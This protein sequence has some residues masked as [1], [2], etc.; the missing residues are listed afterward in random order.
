VF[1]TNSSL[2]RRVLWQSRRCWP[3]LFAIFLLSVLAMGLSLIVPLPLKIAVDS[4][5]GTSAL[6]AFLQPYFPQLTQK[7]GL[8]LA[9]CLMLSTALLINLQG[10]CSGWLQTYTG[11]KLVWDFRAQLLDHVQRL[12]M[13]FHDRNGTLDSAY[14]IQHDA[15]AIQYVVIQGLVPMCTA[16]SALGIMLYVCMRLD[17]QISLIAL[18]IAVPL[19]LLT[20]ACSRQVRNRSNVVKELDSSA[21]N[22]VQEVL[23]SIRLVKAF[24]QE[25][26]EYERFVRHSEKRQARQVKLAFTQGLFNLTIG[27]VIA[28]GSAAA[29]YVGVRHVSMGK[30]TVGDLLI[31]V[32]YIAQLYEP[33]RLV[34][35]KITDLHGWAASLE[36]ALMLLDET[37]EIS[38][39]SNPLPLVRARGH[40]EFR[41]VSFQYHQ[42]QRGLRSI[43]FQVPP[44]ARVGVMGSS[45][46]GKSTLI[47]LLMRFYDP[48]EGA[49][50]LDGHDIRQYRIHDLRRQFSVVLQEPVLFATSVAENI[51]YAKPDASNEEIYA[52]AHA[53]NSHEFISRLPEGY[54]T[55]VGERGSRLSGGERQRISL[56]RAF[57]R[58]SPVLMLDEPTSSVDLQTEAVIASA[59]QSLMRDRTTFI[60]AHRLETLKS[61]DLLLVLRDGE[62]VEVRPG[63]PEEYL[64]AYVES[65]REVKPRHPD[66]AFAAAAK[67]VN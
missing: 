2:L 23:G 16:I 56:A 33:L 10:L 52:A 65:T 32:A 4:I 37:P 9:V 26:R 34:S 58:N 66:L 25:T 7:G 18:S 44:G 3:H 62:L 47:N 45:G 17:L 27:L 38:E 11:E 53:A 20:R 28:T 1:R 24:G 63:A 67:P 21:L 64:A 40:F 61:C 22:V 30:L 14:R 15:P 60:I 5:G 35:T 49:V 46:A 36:R 6:P 13:S 12:P 42:G 50:L 41:N 39:V 8:L 29:L 43:S 54:E 51:A 19:F 48:T 55:G 59:L 31:M 57:L